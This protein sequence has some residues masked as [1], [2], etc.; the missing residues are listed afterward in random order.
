FAQSYIKGILNSAVEAIVKTRSGH[1]KVAEKEYLRMERVM[2]KEYLVRNLSK[3]EEQITAFPEVD[4]M[5]GQIKFG[6]LLNREGINE[7][8]VIIGSDPAKLDKNMQLSKNIIKGDYFGPSGNEAVIGKTL[9]KKLKV[10]VGEE[11]LLVTTDINYSTYALPFKI[12]GI[13]ETGFAQWDKHVLYIPLPKAQ[14]MLDC[15]DSAHELM[16]YL[17]DPELSYAASEKIKKIVAPKA[18]PADSESA[19]QAI[20]WQEDDLISFLPMIQTIWGKILGMV[21]FIVG[22]VI[23]NTMLMA[24]MER[25][26]EIGVMKA[27]GFKDREIFSMILTEAFYIGSIGSLIGGLL[28]GIISA[29]IEKTGIDM[30]STMGQEMWD[31]VELPAVLGKVIY[32]DLTMPILFGSMLFGVLLTL[33]AVLYPAY[34]SRKMSPV[35]AFHS[36]LKV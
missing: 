29:I 13:F 25:Y 9:A 21:M 24:V 18:S 11:V 31:K 20:P 26:H 34:K 17:K 33:A 27:L 30:V 7:P 23:L 2:P 6:G 15:P 32:T 35:E 10:A 8:G 19:V 12:K 16:I 14:E 3:I 1:V 22:L 36:Q 28:G 4:Y 5:V